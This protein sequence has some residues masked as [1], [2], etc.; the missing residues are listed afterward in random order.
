VCNSHIVRYDNTTHSASNF[1]GM[2]VVGD[3]APLY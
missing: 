2:G 1:I 3:D